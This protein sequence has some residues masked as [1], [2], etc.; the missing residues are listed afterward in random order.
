LADFVGK[1]LFTG[2]AVNRV[3]K[4]M[5]SKLFITKHISTALRTNIARFFT[6]KILIVAFA[7]NNTSLT[8]NYLAIFA[9]SIPF[10]EPK[11]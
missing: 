5:L 9:P 11:P 6:A 8:P 7:L 4:I 10:S 1:L 2:L 3:A